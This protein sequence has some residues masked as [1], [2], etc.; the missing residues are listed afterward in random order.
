MKIEHV[1]FWVKDLEIMRNFY[2]QYFGAV[3]NEKYHNPVKNFNL[4]SKF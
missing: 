2:E 4:I 3:S 1:A